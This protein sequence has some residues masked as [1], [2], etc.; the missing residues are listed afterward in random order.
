MGRINRSVIRVSTAAIVSAMALAI[1]AANAQEV[2]AQV[3]GKVNAF[4]AG[5]FW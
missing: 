5:L 2:G 3:I 4:S 1:S